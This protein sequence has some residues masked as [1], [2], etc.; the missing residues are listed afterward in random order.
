MDIFILILGF[1][2]IYAGGQGLVRS[3]VDLA[4]HL[5]WSKLVVGFVVV[6]LGTSAPELAISLFSAYTGHTG[7]LVGN[8]IGSNVANVLLVTGLAATIR[9]LQVIILHS[10]RHVAL[11]SISLLLLL[12]GMWMGVAT[13]WL[14]L[15]MLIA[16]ILGLFA[17]LKKSTPD[18]SAAEPAQYGL[19]FNIV[20]L[21]VAIILLVAGADCIVDGAAGLATRWGISDSVIG[22]SIV[23]IG[24]SLPELVFSMIAAYRRQPE[25]IIGNIVGSNTFNILLGVGLP[26]LFTRI[27]MHAHISWTSIS[28]LVLSTLFLLYFVLQKPKINRLVG[29]GLFVLYVIFLGVI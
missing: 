8:V 5:S 13:W 2:L 24:T 12:F 18:E 21:I 26:S 29:V 22:L 7:I 20:L 16:I 17:I 9:P 14:G 6:G 23:A 4:D 3:A 11:I 15:I 10:K 28:F 19:F 1:I 27:P 25:L